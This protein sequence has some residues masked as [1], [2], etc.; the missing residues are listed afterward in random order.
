MK[1]LIVIIVAIISISLS[2]KAQIRVSYTSLDQI[3]HVFGR[4]YLWEFP[5]ISH[6]LAP[7]TVFIDS[8]ERDTLYFAIMISDS[9]LKAQKCRC[10]LVRHKVVYTTRRR[11]L[12]KLKRVEK[13]TYNFNEHQ[14]CE[15]GVPTGFG[16]RIRT[17]RNS[18]FLIRY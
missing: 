18:T 14:F 15:I 12:I 11:E 7:F 2:S 17:N 8:T 4:F 6:G 16:I 9:A 1:R 13:A 3:R 10:E 5:E